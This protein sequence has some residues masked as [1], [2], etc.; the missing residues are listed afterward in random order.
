MSVGVDEHDRWSLVVVVG[1]IV[2]GMS[3]PFQPRW[4]LREISVIRPG[5][6][7][8][9]HSYPVL[10]RWAKLDRPSGALFLQRLLQSCP[11]GHVF[12]K[13]CQHGFAA[14]G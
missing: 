11:D 5:L 10:K 7:S 9:V 6:K 14:F 1:G 13:T 4:Q 3:L 12:Q 2:Y 8:L